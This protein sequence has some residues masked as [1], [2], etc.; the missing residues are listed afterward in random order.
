[1]LPEI[2][3]AYPGLALTP[4]LGLVPLGSDEVSNLWEFAHLQT[5][6]PAV[7]SGDGKLSLTEGTGLVF[8][9]LPGG[10]FQMGAQKSDPQE[11]NYVPQAE[12]NEGP[13]TQ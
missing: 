10:T 8:V 13:V 9:L 7:R 4:Q 5:G 11:P 12:G 1:V 2:R 6:E 3:S